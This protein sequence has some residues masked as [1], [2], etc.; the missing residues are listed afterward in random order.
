MAKLWE[1]LF[2]KSSLFF[3]LREAITEGKRCAGQPE[4]IDV[5]EGTLKGGW[6]N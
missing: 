6:G 3:I 2:K 4:R 5:H 1:N